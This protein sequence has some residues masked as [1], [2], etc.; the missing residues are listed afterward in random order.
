MLPA[1]H[2]HI[3]QGPSGSTPHLCDAEPRGLRGR[4]EMSAGKRRPYGL[5]RLPDPEI[6]VV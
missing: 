4:A 5:A 1:R 3:L 6:V 2:A